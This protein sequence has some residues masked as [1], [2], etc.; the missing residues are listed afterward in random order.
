MLRKNMTAR[1]FVTPWPKSK[2]A[3]SERP[4][5]R[6]L[7]TLEVLGRGGESGESLADNEQ[8]HELGLV[9]Y[10]TLEFVLLNERTI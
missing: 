2:Q 8:L 6:R 3:L 7:G 4:T 9:D 1:H 10:I 5:S